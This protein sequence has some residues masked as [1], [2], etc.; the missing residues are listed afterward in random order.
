[1]IVDWHSHVYP[2]ELAKQRRW[3][4]GYPLTIENL[5]DAHERAAI[6]LCVVSNTFHY[7][8]EAILG[9]NALALLK[10]SPAREE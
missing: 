3:G 8:R 5:L 6:D 2:P 10:L 4:T 9:L 7:I 1:M